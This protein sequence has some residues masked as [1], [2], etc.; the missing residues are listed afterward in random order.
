MQKILSSAQLSGSLEYWG[1]CDVFKPRPEFPKLR[2]VSGHEGS[3][4][5]VLQEVF[6]DDTKMRVTQESDGK[7]RM[8]ETD[9]PKDLLEVTIHHLSF[10][11][12]Y[13]LPDLL[14]LDDVVERS[15]KSSHAR[16]S[17]FQVYAGC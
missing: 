8:V 10:P 6:A 9:V 5:E 7:V 16:N 11:S 13:S 3:A 1:V 12:N 4:R 17:E 14:I 15:R 2:P